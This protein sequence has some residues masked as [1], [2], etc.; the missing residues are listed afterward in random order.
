MHALKSD[1]RET[2]QAICREFV[3]DPVE[4]SFYKQR[5]RY[6]GPLPQP[7]AEE[8]ALPRQEALDL[9]IAHAAHQFERLDS[10]LLDNVANNVI[11]I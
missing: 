2:N 8:E 7:E 4:A 6:R 11:G 1:D 3:S 5:L 9:E 10:D